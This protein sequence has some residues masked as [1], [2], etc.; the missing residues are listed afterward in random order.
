MK[1]LLISLLIVGTLNSIAGILHVEPT[2]SVKLIPSGSYIEFT[3]DFNV[4]PMLKEHALGSANGVVCKMNLEVISD[5]DRVIR[6]GTKIEIK[7]H[8]MK[9]P[10]FVTPGNKNINTI[11]CEVP[12]REHRDMTVKEFT[13]SISNVANLVMS[14]PIDF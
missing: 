2:D 9:Y 7:F 1:G 14:G 3:K 6:I 8:D 12:A 13:D 4:K 11:F 10:R 5:K